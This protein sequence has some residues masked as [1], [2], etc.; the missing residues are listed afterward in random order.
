MTILS[1]ACKP[2]NFESHNS[3]KL[4]FTNIR[5]R[6]SNFVDCESFLES[7][8]RD[9]LALCR[10][11]LD[12]SIDSGNFSV[13]G[14]LPLIQKDSSTH[15]HGLAVYVKEGLPFARDLSLENSADS[16]LCFRLA[17]LH[18]VSYFFFVY[19]SPSSA[20]CTVFDS[21][22]SNID[23]VLSI[24]PSANVFV[25]GDFNVHHKDWLTY[26]SGTYRPGELCYNFSISSDLAQ[27]VNFPTW[28]PD[29]DSHSPALLDFFLSSDASICSTMA[30]PPLGN[31]DHVV[32]SVS[33]DFLTNSQQ[34]VPFHL[35][36]YDYS[37][38]D[39][40]GLRDHLRDVSWEDVFK[41]GASAAASDFC[42]WIQVRID[43]YISHRKYQVK[44]HPSPWFSAA[45]AA[46]IVHRN[47][48]FRLY[49]KDKSSDSKVKFRQASNRC[50]RVFE[51]AKLAYFNKA[52]E[53]ITSQKLGSRDF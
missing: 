31:S 24:N 38:A 42:E 26:S 25:F 22:S 11:N 49:Q 7:N 43:V 12:D 33:I 52:K 6:R 2:D 3:L 14:Y 19:Q 46:A 5:G 9:I 34:D 47:H 48:F 41:L 15:M 30:F 36:A 16:Y 20:L 32:V 45:C 1:K 18:S 39:W 40:D 28:I 23:E 35:I 29:C 17:L 8:S 44:S 13:R 27:M 4:S 53:S 51:A 10:T 50:K 37:R 21:V